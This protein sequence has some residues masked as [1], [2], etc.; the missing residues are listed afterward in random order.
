MQNKNPSVGGVWIL[1]SGTTQYP[2]FS[3]CI[4]FIL[5]HQFLHSRDCPWAAVSSQKRN[6][7]QVSCNF[8]YAVQV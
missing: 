4:N 2:F 7:V 3:F 8:S 5:S 6:R 1:F